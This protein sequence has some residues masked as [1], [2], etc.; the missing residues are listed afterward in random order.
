MKGIHYN[1]WTTRRNTARLNIRHV[2]IY[3]EETK[4]RAGPTMKQNGTTISGD[5]WCYIDVASPA[6]S[7]ETSSLEYTVVFT[8][9]SV[10]YT[11][12]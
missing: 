8:I 5:K 3:G 9:Q 12:Y 4:I 11:L 6:V 10:L 7:L 2:P 1:V